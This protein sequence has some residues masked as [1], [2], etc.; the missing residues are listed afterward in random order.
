MQTTR[1]FLEA[2]RAKHNGCSYYQVTKI[3][4]VNPSSITR[5]KR[6]HGGFDRSVAIRV[7]D[8]L[9]L[10]HA[11]VIACIE[12]EREQNPEVKPVWEA[13]AASFRNHASILL[14][15]CL[16]AAGVNDARASVN[17]GF[18][19]HP[20]PADRFGTMCI[21]SSRRRTQDRRRRSLFAGLFPRPP[22]PALAA[23]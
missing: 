23:A 20:A 11:Y 7:A 1:D 14:L 15:I 5:W 4:D 12:S 2:I 13:I 22:L 9:E 16:S 21:M 6:G 10:P 18:L 19:A 17:Q 8:E 3:L